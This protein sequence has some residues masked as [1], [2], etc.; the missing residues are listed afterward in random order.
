MIAFLNNNLLLNALVTVSSENAQFPATNL[1][2]D[3][4]TKNWRSTS[5]S[6][7]VTIDLGS[8][9][10]VNSVAIV[11]NWKNGFGFTAV[12]IEGNMTDTWGAPAVSETLSIDS[13]HGFAFADFT[14]ANLRFWRLSFTSTLGYVEVAN[15]V[16]G[17]KL[18]IATN[19]LGYNWSY[20]DRDLKDTDTTRYG[21]EYY[22]L[23]T[24]RKELSSLR[25]DAMDKDEMALF[26]EL[27]DLN[28]T[29]KPFIFYFCDQTGAVIDDADR[30]NGLYK[31]TKKP[32]IT[33]FSSGFYRFTMSLREQK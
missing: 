11:D 33:N 26:Y 28:G 2:N 21:Q 20:L 5:N 29:T 3:F 9:E 14:T 18:E 15:I 8:M 6:D 22:D 13:K 32:A 31:M 17:K 16:I 7:T 27:Y 4:R 25:Y 30:I 24:T 1:K 10:E 23:F 12:T 19:G